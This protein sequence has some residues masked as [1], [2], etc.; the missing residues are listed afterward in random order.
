MAPQVRL[1]VDVSVSHVIQLLSASSSG[2][3]V[4]PSW[5]TI[6]FGNGERLMDGAIAV[7]L[8]QA[9]PAAPRRKH[10]R[11]PPEAKAKGRACRWKDASHMTKA[12][13]T[14]SL[15]SSS[16]AGFDYVPG[17]TEWCW[18]TSFTRSSVEWLSSGQWRAWI[19]SE[20]PWVMSDRNK[21]KH[22]HPLI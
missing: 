19:A 15:F 10:F 7:W 22:L 4:G 6:L 16:A 12:R 8:A 3:S 5:T 2:M 13:V 21:V 1:D 14:S 20:R 17:W 11:Q 18:C 9:P